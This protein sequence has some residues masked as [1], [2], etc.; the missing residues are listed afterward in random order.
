MEK[1]DNSTSIQFNR[2]YAGFVTLSSLGV[3]HLINTCVSTEQTQ[4]ILHYLA[5]SISGIVGYIFYC[6]F[7]PIPTPEQA[8]ARVENWW[9]IRSLNKDLKS[10]TDEDERQSILAELK[11]SKKLGRELRKPKPLSL[12]EP[13]KNDSQSTQAN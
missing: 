6:M 4:T 10:E 8:K 7:A 1:A 5:P 13:T 9:Y 12:E 3:V 2:S 11:R